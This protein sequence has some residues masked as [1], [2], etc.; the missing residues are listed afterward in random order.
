MNLINRPVQ[1]RFS[2]NYEIEAE[3]LKIDSEGLTVKLLN[4]DE[5]SYSWSKVKRVLWFFD[6]IS[7]DFAGRR[8][9]NK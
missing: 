3:L 8:Y 9:K 1:I 2:F 7:K 5:T 4:Q 6:P